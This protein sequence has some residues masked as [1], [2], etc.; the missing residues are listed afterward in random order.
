M[1]SI[2]TAAMFIGFSLWVS[3]I[4]AGQAGWRT[5]AGV[6]IWCAAWFVMYSFESENKGLQQKIKVRV[7]IISRRLDSL[8]DDLE[9]LSMDLPQ[10]RGSQHKEECD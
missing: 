2:C 8:L 10:I 6:L 9:V 1:I 7:G 4:V 5:L 3:D